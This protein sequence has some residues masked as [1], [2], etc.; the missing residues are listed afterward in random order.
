M[1]KQW[2]LWCDGKLVACINEEDFDQPWFSGKII[3]SDG[4]SALQELFVKANDFI[5]AEDFESHALDAVFEAIDQYQLSLKH[6]SDGTEFD[7]ILL[8]ID[9]DHVGWRI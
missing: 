2:E 6:L 7:E 1:N 8:V 9:G 4:F 3:W 5:E